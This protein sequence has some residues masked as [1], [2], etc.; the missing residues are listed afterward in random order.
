[1]E[2]AETGALWHGVVAAGEHVNGGIARF[3]PG[4]NREVRF[5]QQRQTGH[6]LWLEVVCDQVQQCGAGL[7]HGA[8][9]QASKKSFIIEPGWIAAIQ[10]KDAMFA[11]WFHSSV[12]S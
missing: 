5:G 12:V 6:P 10:L 1:M 3:R 8:A 7:L 2:Q 4:M 11:H 9:D